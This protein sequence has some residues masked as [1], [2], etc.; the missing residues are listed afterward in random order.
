MENYQVR[1]TKENFKD[2]VVSIINAD[3]N[4]DYQ[5]MC[6]SAKDVARKIYA[7]KELANIE[8]KLEEAGVNLYK[9]LRPIY[10]EMDQGW[11]EEK[12]PESYYEDMDQ[13]LPDDLDI[14][15]P[16][17]ALYSEVY[18]DTKCFYTLKKE[19]NHD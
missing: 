5:P 16:A 10:L 8:K 12:F 7:D 17:T 13:E 18:G 3:I 9:H 2:V 11:N 14:I 19:D 1:I 6:F 15:A 4:C